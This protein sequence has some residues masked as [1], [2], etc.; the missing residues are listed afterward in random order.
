MNGEKGAVWDI[1]KIPMKAS[2]LYSALILFQKILAGL[3]PSL[4]VLAVARFINTAV[5]VVRGEIGRESIV[6]PIIIVAAL[7]GI[8]WISL[9]VSNLAVTKLECGIRENFRLKVTKKISSLE[10]KYIEDKDTWDLIMRV[11][12]DLE[13]NLSEAFTGLLELSAIAIS[14]G[15]L[16]V[17]LTS[18]IW[19]SGI[20]ITM[21][22]IPL[23]II[24]LKSGKVNYNANREASEYIRKSDYFKEILSG[25]ESAAERTLFAYSEKMGKRYHQEYEIARKIQLKTLI[26]RF[27][28]MKSSSIITSVISLSMILVLIPSTLK[29]IMSIG[30][31]ISVTNGLFALVGNMS[32]SLTH[33]LQQLSKNRE[34]MIDI[35]KLMALEET[36]GAFDAPGEKAYEFDSIE[37]KNVTFA[38]PNTHVKILDGMSFK[39]EKGKHYA[40]VGGNGAGKTTVTK[41]LTGLYTEYTGDILINGKDIRELSQS[42]LKS[43]FALVY[44]DF[45]RYFITVKENIALGDINTIESPEGEKNIQS[46]MEVMSLEE[47]IKKLP[48]GIDTPLGKILEGGQDLSG[49]QWQRLAM[50]RT[51]VNN[52][53]LRILDEPTAALDPISESRIYEEF[54]KIGKGATTIFI[55]HRLGSTKLAQEI[56]VLSKGKVVEKGSH[57]ELLNKKGVYTEMYESQRSWY[58][59]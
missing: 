19:W 30:M 24:A 31:F 7:I 29:G 32:W 22:A 34:I 49:G 27:I 6:L 21:L 2:K 55:S 9:K 8:N 37:F 13:R 26:K 28:I 48:K 33:Y 54:H 11:T 25:R 12:K 41:L 16:I 39:I 57:Q 58:D 15:G 4:T 10:Y 38:Y 36:E 43:L 3:I 45:A 17:I 50:A 35:R 56:F 42:E 14:A 44:Q 53:S 20:V 59:A 5:A 51:L 18:Q 46:A 52:A 1:I 47:D 40:F 23:T